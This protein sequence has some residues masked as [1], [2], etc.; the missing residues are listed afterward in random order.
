VSAPGLA[1]CFVAI[2]V[3]ALAA[4]NI[5]P[6]IVGNTRAGRRAR[7]WSRP[8]SQA[9]TTEWHVGESNSLKKNKRGKQ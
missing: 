9:K 7:H 5:E 8:C 4:P 1:I 2:I 3:A 6:A